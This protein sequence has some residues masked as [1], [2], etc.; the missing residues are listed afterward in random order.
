MTVTFRDLAG[1][2]RTLESLQPLVED[3][4]GE[5]EV[6]VKDGGTR[7][8]DEVTRDYPWVRL[9]SSPDSG[10]YDAMNHALD[11]AAGSFVWFLNGGDEALINKWS[12]LRSVLSAAGRRGVL[13][14]YQA[15]YRRGLLHRRARKPRSIRHALPTSHQAIFY[16]EASMRLRYDLTYRVAADYA[17]T[18]QS[19]VSGVMW[20]VSDLEVARFDMRDG[21]SASSHQ[22][23]RIEAERIQ[24]EILGIGRLS[25]AVSAMRHRLSATVRRVANS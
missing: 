21:L 17:F 8:I 20:M 4:G 16:P 6:I 25:R 3:S 9:D 19:Y 12:Q 14:A 1:L 7:N 23:I 22:E 11:S 10:I 2:R 13:T 24:R 5:V 15:R 18:A